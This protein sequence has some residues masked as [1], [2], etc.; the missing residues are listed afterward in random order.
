MFLQFSFKYFQTWMENLVYI[1]SI[2]HMTIY[3]RYSKQEWN[4]NTYK[5]FNDT[6]P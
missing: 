1:T 4:M 3:N 6:A 2:T 5:V